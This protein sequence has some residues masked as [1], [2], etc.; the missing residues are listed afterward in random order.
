VP[1]RPLTDDEILEAT[2]VFGESLD[3]TR[4]R[5]TRDDP[6]SF[7][8]PKTIGDTVHLRSD[9]GLFAENG[10]QLSDR[11]RS[12]LVHELVHVWQFQNGGLA[13]IA[14]SLWAQHVAF[15]RTGSRGGAYRWQRAWQAGLP[16]AQWNPEQQAQAIQDLRDARLRVA[17]GVP[18]EHDPVRIHRLSGLLDELRAGRGAPRFPGRYPPG[19]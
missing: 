8:A 6:L 17:A 4:V 19:S 3:V 5:I 1:S 15:L 13:Y 18:E 14:A 7:V 9:W 16:W 10:L 2:D 11:G 12:I